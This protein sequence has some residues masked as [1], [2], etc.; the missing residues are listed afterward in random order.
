MEASV[1]ATAV[2]L[3]PDDGRLV[4]GRASRE[5]ILRAAR[6]LFR[7]HGFDG[8][9][10]R[11]IAGRAGMGASSLYRHIRSKEELLVEDLAVR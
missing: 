4:R 9:T 2:T 5:R 7:E 6:E 3:R 8:A 1:P 10:L 11:A